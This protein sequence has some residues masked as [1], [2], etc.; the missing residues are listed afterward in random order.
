MS[1]LK[2]VSPPNLAIMARCLLLL[3]AALACPVAL[4]ALDQTY[5]RVLTAGDVLGGEVFGLSRTKD[6]KPIF[7]TDYEVRVLS[8]SWNNHIQRQACHLCAAATL[9]M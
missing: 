2:G 3:I 6:G 8:V 5:H 7:A 4:A 9:A 1:Q